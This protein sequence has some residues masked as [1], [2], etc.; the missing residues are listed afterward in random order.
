MR[1]LLLLGLLEANVVD[2]AITGHDLPV[3]GICASPP[4][5]LTVLRCVAQASGF[6]FDQRDFVFQH[7][8]PARMRRRARDQFRNHPAA[9]QFCCSVNRN[10]APNSFSTNC[11]SLSGKA[12]YPGFA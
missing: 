10:Q 3:D 5:V 4:L 8:R 1:P 6:L 9:A 2:V 12:T 7:Q 11:G